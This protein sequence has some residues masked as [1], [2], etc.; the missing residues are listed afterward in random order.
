MD[1][2]TP[3]LMPPNAAQIYEQKIID[4]VNAAGNSGV[5]P[6]TIIAVMF[7]MMVRVNEALAKMQSAQPPQNPN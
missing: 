4:A 6:A 3:Q 2:N 5:N 7:S 1:K